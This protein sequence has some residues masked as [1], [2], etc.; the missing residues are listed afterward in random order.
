M[1][2]KYKFYIPGLKSRLM[3]F[4]EV[5]T[6][7]RLAELFDVKPAAMHHY[8]SGYR[9]I[10]YDLL[11]KIYKFTNRKNQQ[12]NLGW[13]LT[14]EG[15]ETVGTASAIETYNVL[16]EANRLIENKLVDPAVVLL[17]MVLKSVEVD[18]WELRGMIE[19]CEVIQKKVLSV[20]EIVSIEE[21]KLMLNMVKQITNQ[22]S[23][24]SSSFDSSL[25]EQKKDK[26]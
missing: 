10:P 15:S 8:L 11:I 3:T 25:R 5:S 2:K 23:L 26:V 16:E 20:G 12:I 4:C 7:R 14:E 1:D 18:S 24:A 9:A 13:L 22:T 19:A 6:E 17:G 21:A